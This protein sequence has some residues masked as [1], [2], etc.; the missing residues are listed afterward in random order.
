MGKKTHQFEIQSKMGDFLLYSS[1]G[2]RDL[3][4]VSVCLPIFVALHQKDWGGCNFLSGAVDSFLQ[5]MS[6]M[7]SYQHPEFSWMDVAVVVWWISII[8]SKKSN[9]YNSVLHGPMSLKCYVMNKCPTLKTFTY[10]CSCEGTAPP[11]GNR[12]SQIIHFNILLLGALIF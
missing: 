2:L 5:H 12:Q 10:Y 6:G 11:T 1:L 8:H 7:K 9:C 3:M 4:Y